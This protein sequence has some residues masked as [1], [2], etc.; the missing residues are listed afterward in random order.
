M[1][2][3]RQVVVSFVFLLRKKQKKNVLDHRRRSPHFFTRRVTVNGWSGGGRRRARRHSSFSSLRLVQP[4][5][6]KSR[7]SSFFTSFPHQGG[8][9]RTGRHLPRWPED[10]GSTFSVGGAK[11]AEWRSLF[12]LSARPKDT[13]QEIGEKGG[14]EGYSWIQSIRKKSWAKDGSLPKRTPLTYTP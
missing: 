10:G 9:T 12:F 1:S 3:H 13:S 4:Q 2:F 8:N 7:L 11:E 6:R 5:R 14:W